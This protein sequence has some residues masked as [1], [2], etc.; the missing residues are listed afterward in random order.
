[1]MYRTFT[2]H[3]E[4][5]GA[6]LEICVG[7]KCFFICTD[8]VTIILARQTVQVLGGMGRKHTL[9]YLS[10]NNP[11]VE[12]KQC[13]SNFKLKQQGLRV[14]KQG[15][16]YQQGCWNGTLQYLFRYYIMWSILKFCLKSNANSWNTHALH[17][18][19][20]SGYYLLYAALTT[21]LIFSSFHHETK[22]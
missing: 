16:Q 9:E 8:L 20:I 1:M 3:Q 17:M 14:I 2:M 12:T 18:T 21:N 22:D 4:T 5:K 7:G 13:K 10:V 6:C 15:K 11:L 19:W